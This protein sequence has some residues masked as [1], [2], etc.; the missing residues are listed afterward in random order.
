MRGVDTPENQKMQPP[1]RRAY[2]RF[3]RARLYVHGGFV[4]VGACFTKKEHGDR[5]IIRMKEDKRW[6]Q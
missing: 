2:T 3:F 1:H 6:R 5:E 4:T